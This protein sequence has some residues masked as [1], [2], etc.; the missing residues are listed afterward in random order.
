VKDG[1]DGHRFR[2]RGASF[3]ADG[4]EVQAEPAVCPLVYA[5]LFTFA[6]ADR[7]HEVPAATVAEEACASSGRVDHIATKGRC[8]LKI[9]ELTARSG[10]HAGEGHA[11]GSD[12]VDKEGGISRLGPPF[13]VIFNFQIPGDPPLSLVAAWA[14]HPEC[15]GPDS[16]VP[17]QVF[18]VFYR[19]VDIPL[20]SPRP[21]SGETRAGGGGAADREGGGA[22]VA[23]PTASGSLAPSDSHLWETSDSD[24]DSSGDE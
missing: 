3:L 17:P 15:L 4:R 10:G 5:E 8:A 22:A 12:D 16:R 9:T 20:S 19:L 18:G 13:L 7:P 23:S 11:G 14:V 1:G 6:S 2:V 21:S 24:R